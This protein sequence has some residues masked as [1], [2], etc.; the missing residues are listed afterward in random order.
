MMEVFINGHF[1]PTS[2]ATVSVQDRG[3]LYGDGL[4]ETIRAEGGRPLWL[5]QHLERLE[6]SAA[7]INLVPPPDFP[8]ES[9]IRELLQ[10]NG[11]GH[12]LAAVKILITRGEIATLGL[13][14]TDQPTIIIYARQYKPPPAEEYRCGWPV[15]SFPESRTTFL[16]RHKSLNYLFCLAARQYAV[17]R[18]GREGLILEANGRVSEGSTTGVLWQDNDSFFTPLA[19]SALASVTVAVLREALRHEGVTLTEKPVTVKLLAL[20]QGVWL[21]NSLIGL[22]PVSSLDGQILAVSVETERLNG[23]LWSKVG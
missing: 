8:W 3:L 14:E 4:F 6:Q 5:G 15:V 18:G 2:Q 19:G 12:G 11:L 7:V 1:L 21:A 9:R 17:D 23:L 13:P 20:A 16:S 10:R 22:L